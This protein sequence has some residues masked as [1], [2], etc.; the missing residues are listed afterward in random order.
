MSG[1]AEP[2]RTPQWQIG[3][4]VTMTPLTTDLVEALRR[5]DACRVSN[6][7]ETFDCRLRNEGFADG[8]IRAVFEDLPP[9]VG[10]AVTARVRCSTPPPVGH[11]YDDRTD[12]WSYLLTV[13]APRI[14]VVEDVDD[15]PG[16]GAFIGGVHA[17]ILQALGCAAYVTN[18]SVRDV[19]LVRELGVQLFAATLSVSH[20]FVHLVDFGLAVTVG[21]LR[22]SSG[23]LVYG[24]RHGVLTIPPA[25][26]ADIPRV[27]A[28][29]SEQEQRVVELCRSADF[30]LER[31]QTLVRELE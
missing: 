13:P 1:S 11:N 17:S 15:R 25:I 30:S 23:D 26:A 28:R 8:S 27:A 2:G 14:V 16:L 20:A 6:A 31:L 18:G 21:G 7:I 10:H 19:A 3:L 12:W 24:D 5:L 4:G 22:V 9:V 29:M